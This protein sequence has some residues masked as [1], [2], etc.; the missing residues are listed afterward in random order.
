MTAAQLLACAVPHPKPARFG[1]AVSNAIHS[2]RRTT[3]RDSGIGPP[4]PGVPEDTEGPAAGAARRRVGTI[5]G[6]IPTDITRHATQEEVAAMSHPRD[7]AQTERTVLLPPAAGGPRSVV[8]AC[9][10]SCR[11][12]SWCSISTPGR[13]RARTPGATQRKVGKPASRC[14]L[15]TSLHLHAT[16]HS[17]NYRYRLVAGV[18]TRNSS[19]P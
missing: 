15:C 11:W 18:S 9:S 19:A 14:I 8:A 16:T 17:I 6:G 4:L 5:V 3:T 13:P 1:R 2:D 10:T 7:S 12:A